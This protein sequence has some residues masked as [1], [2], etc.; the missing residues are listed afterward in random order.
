[1]QSVELPTSTPQ[2]NKT[3]KEIENGNEKL[4]TTFIMSC[5]LR[6]KSPPRRTCQQTATDGTVTPLPIPWP[7]RDDREKFTWCTD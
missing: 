4:G 3:K 5:N 7:R 1:M 6:G 2:K